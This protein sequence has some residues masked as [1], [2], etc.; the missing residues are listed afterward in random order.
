MA[1]T[2]SR[3]FCLWLDAFL[4][5]AGRALTA[6]ET[7]IVRGRLCEVF[8]HEIDPAMGDAAHQASLQRIHRAVR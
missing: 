4:G 8:L 3:D 5:D 2:T 7:A 1:Q 6:G